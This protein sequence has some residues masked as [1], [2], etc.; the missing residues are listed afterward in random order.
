MATS[1]PASMLVPGDFQVQQDSIKRRRELLD[2]L[3]QQNKLGEGTMVS[4]HY[5][6]PHWSQA[7]ADLGSQYLRM[8]K[9]KELDQEQS[10]S[11]AQNR[12][13]MGEAIQ[14]YMK[15]RE[16]YDQEMQGPT[17][18]GSA[19]PSQH[20]AGDPRKAL[21]DAITSGYGPLQQ[22]G[23][24]DMA[25]Q[26]KQ[27]MTPKDI[28]A[29]A[30]E[31]KYTPASVQRA[32][33]AGDPSLMQPFGKTHTVNNQLISVGDSDTPK[34]LGDYR[35]QFG[36]VT[37]VGT[38]AQG[39]PIQGQTNKATGEVKFAP[40]GTTVNVDTAEKGA[41][42]LSVEL[43]KNVA[44]QLPV[45]ME[46]AKKSQM[47]LGSF[48]NAKELV[49]DMPGGIASAP[50]QT[51]KR[52]LAAFGMDDPSIAS[53]EQAIAT[54]KQGILENAKQLG[55]G[56]GFTNQDYNELAK[57]VGA[58]ASLTPAT[59]NYAINKGLAGAV[60][61]INNHA[62]L[63]AKAGGMQG[64]DPAVLDAFKVDLPNFSLNG[65]EF[66]WDAG[67][68]QFVAKG[69]GLQRQEATAGKPAPTQ[70]LSAAEQAELAQLRKRFQGK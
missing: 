17:Q 28:Y 60:N 46:A 68:K 48:Q 36:T 20:V 6:A 66:K 29:L 57:I 47:A 30:G 44:A 63:V 33:Q 10:D 34:L 26:G 58:D 23:M 69:S 70:P 54:L 59:L 53:N 25:S 22:I 35:D 42:A 11:I 31:G 18:D 16:G 41:N 21:V 19:M 64:A 61:N 8:K 52:L 45:S 7:I 50:I 24:A 27:T 56:S 14:N 43:N 5:I 62:R 67:S 39:M 55:S 65:D 2:A 9:G 4:G 1:S 49:K 40:Q 51:V 38:N 37:G 12:E 15:T 32:A 3:A 13:G